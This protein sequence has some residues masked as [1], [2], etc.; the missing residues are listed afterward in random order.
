MIAQ[1]KKLLSLASKVTR[2]DCQES[3]NNVIGYVSESH[4]FEYLKQIYEVTLDALKE[5][6]GQQ[7]P[8]W[9]SLRVALITA[10]VL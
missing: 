6:P 1:Y 8:G 3:I 4:D 10:G 5:L 9:F 7:V 2:N